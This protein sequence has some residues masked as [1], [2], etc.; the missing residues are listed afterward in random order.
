MGQSR[1]VRGKLGANH[2]H[3]GHVLIPRSRGTNTYVKR[4]PAA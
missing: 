1:S 4:R 3:A 2:Y